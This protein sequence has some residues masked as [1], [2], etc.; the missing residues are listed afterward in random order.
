MLVQYTTLMTG[1]LGASVIP[2]PLQHPSLEA[3]SCSVPGE[4]GTESGEG[5]ERRGGGEGWRRGEGG[6]ER[7]EWC[8]EEK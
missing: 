2:V 3:V 1:L 4:V 5:E 6:G 8:R 7:R